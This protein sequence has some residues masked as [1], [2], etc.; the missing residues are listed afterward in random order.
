MSSQTTDR[1]RNAEKSVAQA[2]EA[3]EKAEAGLAA[4]ETVATKVDDVRSRPVL[5]T[6]LMFGLLTLVGLF[7]FMLQRTDD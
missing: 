3:L 7:V 4:A 1:I 6:G 5:K 2:R